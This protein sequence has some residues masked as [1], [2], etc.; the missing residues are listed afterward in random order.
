MKK[1]TNGGHCLE[2]K[3]ELPLLAQIQSM[4]GCPITSLAYENR[5]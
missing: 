4:L 2:R 5:K 3:R 1:K